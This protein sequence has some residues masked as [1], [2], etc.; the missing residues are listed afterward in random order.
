ML[1]RYVHQIHQRRRELNAECAADIARRKVRHAATLATLTQSIDAQ[2]QAHDEQLQ[3]W[4]SANASALES[5]AEEKAHRYEE[6]FAQTRSALQLS[7]AGGGAPLQWGGVSSGAIP[8]PPSR[9]RGASPRVRP[10]ARVNRHGSIAI[11]F[12]RRVEEVM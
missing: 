6:V 7:D 8:S 1:R 11:G 2:V 9:L 5:A 3:K 10:H 12:H 4:Y